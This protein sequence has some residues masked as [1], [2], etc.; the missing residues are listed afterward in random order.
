MGG[1]K[2]QKPPRGVFFVLFFS[3]QGGGGKPKLIWI[4]P[5]FLRWVIFCSSAHR[6][7]SFQK[8]AEKKKN[9]KIY[10]FARLRGGEWQ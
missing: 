2:K 3:G 7:L 1:K 9:Q 8:I 5:L 6:A 10:I 4:G